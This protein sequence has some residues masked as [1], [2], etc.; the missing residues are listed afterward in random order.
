MNVNWI[1]EYRWLG[2]EPE[3]MMI[4]DVDTIETALVEARYSLDLAETP[5][6]IVGIK[7]R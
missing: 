7:Q 2:K 4:F 1:V 3:S 6:V 5:Y